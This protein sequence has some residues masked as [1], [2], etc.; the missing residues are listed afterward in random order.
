MPVG[1]TRSTL[2][3]RAGR[4]FARC[5]ATARAI[6]PT[7][8][9]CPWMARSRREASST[10]LGA[11]ERTRSRSALRRLHISRVLAPRPLQLQRARAR[12]APGSARSRSRTLAIEPRKKR[13]GRRSPEDARAVGARTVVGR[14]TPALDS[15]RRR[16]RVSAAGWPGSQRG[17]YRRPEVTYPRTSSVTDVRPG[18]RQTFLGAARAARIRPSIPHGGARAAPRRERL[19]RGRARSRSRN[20]SVTTVS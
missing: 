11:C 12:S 3:G 5:V 8:T 2:S 19:A 16:D 4:D 17:G 1:P 20:V 18:R 6:R 7:A 15:R 9:S 10:G 13:R 14:V